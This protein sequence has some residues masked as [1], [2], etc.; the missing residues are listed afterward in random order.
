[1]DIILLER[2]A[3]LG[4]VGDVVAVRPGYGRNFL[5]PQEKAVRAT[6]ANKKEFEARRAVLEKRNAEAKSE[7]EK[8]AKEIG[9]LSVKVVR[10]ASEDGR[11]YGSVNARDVSTAIEE[12][13]SHNIERR[14]IDLGETIKSL[15]LYKATITLHPEV[16]LPLDVQ[17]VR[18]M[19]ASA[20]DE[21]E[22]EE[23]AAEQ[24]PVAQNEENTAE[25]PNGEEAA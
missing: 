3:G 12:Q 14:Q 23:S 15:G 2:I 4:N 6:E 25:E 22:A 18:S 10:Q 5:I 7:A 21:I 20:Y 17:V 16:K 1:M 9:E 19:E 8:R 24:Q 11:L 13:F